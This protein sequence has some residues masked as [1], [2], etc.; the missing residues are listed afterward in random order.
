MGNEDNQLVLE[1]ANIVGQE[2]VTSDPEV[3]YAY[4]RDVN[5]TF[6]LTTGGGLEQFP[7]DEFRQLTIREWNI[8]A[9]QMRNIVRSL[10]LPE[11]MRIVQL[12][13]LPKK[14]QNAGTRTIG[15]IHK[16]FTSI[17]QVTG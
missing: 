7:F 6:P 15:L 11:F 8:I 1:L 12:F 16:L 17:H 4:S 14:G 3:I 5:L 10:R 2:W 13:L 9:G